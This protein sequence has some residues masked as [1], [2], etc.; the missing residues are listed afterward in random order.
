MQITVGLQPSEWVMTAG[1]SPGMPG[2][3]TEKTE[4]I[5]CFSGLQRPPAVATGTLSEWCSKQY[6]DNTLYCHLAVRCL[7]PL[8]LVLSP[9]T[10][11]SL[12]P[13]S[14]IWLRFTAGTLWDSVSCSRIIWHVGLRHWVWNH[15]PSDHCNT[16]IVALCLTHLL[17]RSM[18]DWWAVFM[19]LCG[20]CV[21]V[22]PVL[23][24][25]LWS[26]LCDGSSSCF[27][28]TTAPVSH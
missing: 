28:P 22:V 8:L 23:F 5:I 12:K 24:C 15:W 25:S 10:S 18:K 17:L 20:F 26:V 27:L 3:D 21:H 16:W 9:M 13:V 19:T 7:F 14:E 6:K 1:W 2:V 11:S 4:C